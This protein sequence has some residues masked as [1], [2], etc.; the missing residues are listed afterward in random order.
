MN[1]N[2]YLQNSK[3]SDIHGGEWSTQGGQQPHGCWDAPRMGISGLLAIGHDT[4]ICDFLV[5]TVKRKG[6]E[7]PLSFTAVRNQWTPAWMRTVYRSETETDVYKKSGTVVLEETKCFL[8]NGVFVS[9]ITLRNDL[10][11]PAEL[12][13]SLRSPYVENGMF[14][15]KTNAGALHAV[16]PID[17]YAETLC[18]LDGCG[19]YAVTVPAN[20]SITF[21]WV[22][23]ASPK[24]KIA[25]LSAGEAALTKDE[26]FLLA[27]ENLNRWFAENIPVLETENEDL[28]KVY[29]YRFWILYR[30]IHTPSDV[31][32]GHFLKRPCM[33]ESPF[34]SWYG[35]PVGLPF[36]LHIL[37]ARW[38]AKSRIAFDD[39]RN[40]AENL[41]DYQNYIQSPIAAFADLYDL[42]PDKAWLREI[43][44]ACVRYL[45]PILALGEKPGLKSLP[46]MHGSWLTGAEYQPSFYE[47][48]EPAWDWT[49]DEEG[50]RM[51]LTDTRAPLYRLDEICYTIGNLLGCAKLAAVLGERET[52]ETMLRRAQQMTETV[53]E[54][55]WC[56]EDGFFYDIDVRTGKLCRNS[57]CY[58]SFFPFLWHIAGDEYRG[59]FSRLFSEAHFWARFPITTADKTCPMFWFDNC[60]AGPATS[61]VQEPHEY[62]CSW[63]GTVW[64]YANGLVLTALGNAAKGAPSLRESWLKFFASYTEL[65]FD[66]GDR[67]TPVVVE[68]YRN[69]DGSNF[70]S[71]TDYFHSLWIDIFMKYYIGIDVHDGAFSVHPFTDEDFSLNGVF[72][73][74][75]IYRIT[76]KAKQIFI[77]EIK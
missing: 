59:I 32:P 23:S 71:V 36:P 35:C 44:P 53:L 50:V 75:K 16:F 1:V 7:T 46:V 51:G 69:S 47:H 67:S 33:Y 52:E 26:P 66:S 58:D 43:F 42:K 2:L 72:I 30:S 14:H 24:S 68:H 62:G 15:G 73:K 49:Q 40:W 45:E 29:Y 28:R 76:Q 22:F 77:D 13:I 8:P 20:G 48:T 19:E 57:A 11:E 27:E 5:P 74:G 18:T 3:R 60:I 54:R 70:S 25:A 56:K 55:F 37:E 65:H 64:P 10:R 41:G 21:R 6:S 63:N 61:S 38:L 34:G 17:L 39:A 9:R 4:G 31:I 12:V